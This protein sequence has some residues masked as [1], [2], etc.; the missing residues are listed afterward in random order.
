MR[1]AGSDISRTLYVCQICDVACKQSIV[2]KHGTV[3][4]ILLVIFFIIFYLI[5]SPL[6]THAVCE[7]R[8]SCKCFTVFTRTLHREPLKRCGSRRECLPL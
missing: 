3:H 1:C 7:F 4:A 6:S 8:C 5:F 2:Q